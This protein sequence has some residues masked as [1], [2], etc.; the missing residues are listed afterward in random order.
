MKYLTLYSLS[1]STLKIN[2]KKFC[3][4]LT[5]YYFSRLE[6]TLFYTKTSKYGT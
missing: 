5:G 6:L 4:F 1:I 3:E 2:E